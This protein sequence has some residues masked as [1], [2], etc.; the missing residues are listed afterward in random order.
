MPVNLSPTETFE[1]R[2]QFQRRLLSLIRQSETLRR[3]FVEGEPVTANDYRAYLFSLEE[4][5]RMIRSNLHYAREVL[6]LR[7][8]EGSAQTPLPEAVAEAAPPPSL[9]TT[10]EDRSWNEYVSG[11]AA[12]YGIRPHLYRD[13]AGQMWFGVPGPDGLLTEASYDLV[14]DPVDGSKHAI[15]RTETVFYLPLN[16]A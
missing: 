6:A 10:T 8:R 4:A 5:E 7:Y 3:K 14:I 1:P 11:W 15:P 12:S 9:P 2:T 13:G 16:R